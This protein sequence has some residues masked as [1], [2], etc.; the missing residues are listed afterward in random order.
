MRHI[1][2]GAVL[3]T[4]LTACGQQESNTTTTEQ[5]QEP[6][7]LVSGISLENM[8][9]S[10]RPGDDFFMYVNGT[11]VNE[12]EIPA[13]KASYGGFR[14][15]RD[16]AEEDVKAIIEASASGDFAK[17]SDEQ[18]VGDLY[19]SYMDMEARKTKGLAP[20]QAEL[21]RIAAI[22]NHEQ[23]AVYFAG[24]N[25][26]GYDVPM[27]VAQNEDF[28][29]PQF[30]MIYAWQGGLGLPD[31]EYYFKDD[32]ASASLRELYVAHIEAMFDLAGFDDPAG[33]AAKIMALEKSALFTKSSK[34][35]PSI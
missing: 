20:L 16:E 23:L 21:D 29:D 4:A 14:I 18:K 31:R 11:W 10:V 24:A 17:G 15:L 12:T 8:D 30:Y 27:G 2:P 28:K 35:R 3:L 13:D 32:E 26:R 5:A 9:T 25:R 1:L 7:T 19:K 6:Q 33:S 34:L 22:E